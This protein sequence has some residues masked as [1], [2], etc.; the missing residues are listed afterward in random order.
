[1]DIMQEDYLKYY[2]FLKSNKRRGIHA[3]RSILADETQAKAFAENPAAVA[4]VLA[5][6]KAN[7]DRN[8][9][10][11]YELLTNSSVADIASATYTLSSYGVSS[12]E[13]LAASEDL[14]ARAA[15]NESTMNAI[16]ASGSAMEA[17][18]ES[19]VA[20]SAIAASETAMTAIAAREGASEIISDSPI[21]FRAIAAND[22]AVSIAVD[23]QPIMEA[24]ASDETAAGSVVASELSLGAVADSEIAAGAFAASVVGMNAIA[25]SPTARD[26]VLASSTAMGKV[27]ESAVASAKIVAGVIGLDPV[28]YADFGGIAS[29]GSAMSAVAASSS[30]MGICSRS[31]SALNAICKVSAARTS[32]MNSSYAHA[33]YDD[34]YETLHSAPTSLFAKYESYY[35]TTFLTS[36]FGSF[37]HYS[38]CTDSSGGVSETNSSTKSHAN[39]IPFGGITLLKECMRNGSGSNDTIY[40][41]YGS[42]QTKSN[43]VTTNQTTATAAKKVLVGGMSCYGNSTY[44]G[45]YLSFKYATYVAV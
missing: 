12:F 5:F 26:I 3:L 40:C 18:A 22:A 38:F 29:S 10:Q 2:L 11:L 4:V 25:A 6:D 16:A 20:M 35:D 44:I 27:C 14:M 1:M 15:E 41:Y 21:A 32:W 31:A 23:N 9:E 17:M 28:G 19:G 33:S 42:S 24:I 8:A 39:A 45:N 36:S 30:A 7:P 37:N 13:E 34:V 43:L